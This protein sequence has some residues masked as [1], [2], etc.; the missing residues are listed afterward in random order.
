MLRRPGL[1]KTSLL[2]RRFWLHVSSPWIPPHSQT[3]SQPLLPC[4]ALSFALLLAT[5][6]MWAV[7]SDS[8]HHPIQFSLPQTVTFMETSLLMSWTVDNTDV[9]S[10]K[11]LP[12][13]PGFA[14]A[15]VLLSMNVLPNLI[16]VDETDWFTQVFW[17][18]S[19][20]FV[21]LLPRSAP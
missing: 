16:G 14:L 19:G 2:S 13:L 15:G 3:G 5:E 17:F 8:S 1:K 6:A 7:F 9:K 11:P 18:H 10:K 12:R 20:L 4:P 21:Y